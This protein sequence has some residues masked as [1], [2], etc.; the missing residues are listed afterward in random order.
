MVRAPAAV[1]LHPPAEL[2]VSHQPHPAVVAGLLESLEERIDRVCQ[3]GKQSGMRRGLPGM[4]IEAFEADIENAS[5]E[6]AVD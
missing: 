2:R 1:L 5:T 4:R 3:V 6:P